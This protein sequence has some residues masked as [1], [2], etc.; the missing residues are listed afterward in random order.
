MFCWWARYPHLTVVAR[1]TWGHVLQ[2]DWVG[3]A[4][5][6]MT[7]SPM[8]P[9]CLDPSPAVFTIA[10][11]ANYNRCKFNLLS[12]SRYRC[13]LDVMKA[14]L[15]EQ[16][17]LGLLEETE[18][19]PAMANPDAATSSYES[20]R[21]AVKSQPPAGTQDPGDKAN[22]LENTAPL[23][24]PQAIPDRKSQAMNLGPATPIRIIRFSMNR[25]MFTDVLQPTKGRRIEVIHVHSTICRTI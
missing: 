4:R 22:E 11:A 8:A 6:V 24:L 13:R 17:S 21:D 9:I 3:L 7:E 2:A 1:G 23:P 15:D 25:I 5:R 12:G 10:A 19:A 16:A 14:V 20:E 18:S